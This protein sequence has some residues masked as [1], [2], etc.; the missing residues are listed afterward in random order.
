[1]DFNEYVALLNSRDKEGD[2][3]L[4]LQWLVSYLG[5][6]SVS[7]LILE[8]GS[9]PED[10]RDAGQYTVVNWMCKDRVPRNTEVY[11]KLINFDGGV[12]TYI[13]QFKSYEG[14]SEVRVPRPL[15]G[16]HKFREAQERGEKLW[17]LQHHHEFSTWVR[18]SQAVALITK[19]LS[20]KLG[21]FDF[22]QTDENC[23]FEDHVTSTQA[24][25]PEGLEVEIKS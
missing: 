12:L 22:D 6:E 3:R 10:A 23:C 11:Y 16:V 14:A 13:S 18:Q 21:L 19:S 8:I 5:F 25:F 9:L 24:S 2:D 1:M 20:S 4:R 15:N 17:T 7:D